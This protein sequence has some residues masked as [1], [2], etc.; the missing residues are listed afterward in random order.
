MENKLEVGLRSLGFS[1]VRW[2]TTKGTMYDFWF[3]DL[4]SFRD[5][6]IACLFFRRRK[7]LLRFLT[8]RRGCHVN[9]SPAFEKNETPLLM[10]LTRSFSSWQIHFQ[11]ACTTPTS[12]RYNMFFLRIFSSCELNTA[13]LIDFVKRSA[14][15]RGRSPKVRKR[16]RARPWQKASTEKHGS[17]KWRS[18]KIYRFLSSSYHLGMK[19]TL[20]KTE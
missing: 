10:S 3:L 17:Q 14:K 13:L 20:L 1:C 18:L 2:K 5:R 16:V 6:C 4:L 15:E 7:R 11:M 19:L 9:I 12:P 8:L